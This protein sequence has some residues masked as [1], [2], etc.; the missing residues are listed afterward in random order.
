[1]DELERI[2]MEK[3]KKLLEK[4]AKYETGAQ[5]E[6]IKVTDADFDAT[7]KKYPLLL[8]DFWAAW[9]NPCRIIAPAVEALAKEYAGKL[10]CAKLD[11]DENP[12]TATKFQVFSIPALL[13]FRNSK[14]VDRIVGAVPK[15]HIEVRIKQHLA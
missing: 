14:L 7:L 5:I 1:M 9:C 15:Q 13:L 6:P 4:T 12:I 10:T 3:M 2:K 11:V 8:V